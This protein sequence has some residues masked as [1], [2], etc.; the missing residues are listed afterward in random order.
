[1]SCN[2]NERTQHGLTDDDN[3]TWCIKQIK[4]MIIS[5]IK[6]NEN[7]KKLIKWS[8]I[9]RINNRFIVVLKIVA[10]FFTLWI[11]VI[12]C[13]NDKCDGISGERTMLN[14][15]MAD[16]TP[17]IDNSYMNATA[18]TTTNDEVVKVAT[19]DSDR[20]NSH[21]VTDFLSN[22]FAEFTFKTHHC[23]QWLR[24][25]DFYF[26]VAFMLF[27]IAFLAPHKSYGFLIARCA[28]VFGSIVLAMRSY[29]IECSLYGL[30]YSGSFLIVNCI[31]LFVLVYKMTPVYFEKEIDAVITYR[32][33]IIFYFWSIQEFL[34]WCSSF[35]SFVFLLIIPAI[36]RIGDM[37]HDISI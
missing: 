35:F 29:L 6:S 4:P 36:A 22:F 1:M 18:A 12:D 13:V 10:F 27:L 7:D 16:T 2:W 31:Y 20:S 25:Q 15:E 17:T 24:I 26:H 8:C 19:G 21:D 14:A 9:K 3:N 32:L 33:T 23:E 34:F 37:W 5:S 30:I 28:L 11:C